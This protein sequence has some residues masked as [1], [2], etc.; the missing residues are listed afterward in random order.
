M[1]YSI[2]P[3]RPDSFTPSG[4]SL[5]SDQSK[6]EGLDFRYGAPERPDSFTPSGVSLK[7]DQSKREGLDFRYGA[8]ERPDSLTPS[9]VYLKSDQ[10]KRGF[11]FRDGAP[12]FHS[13]CCT[14]KWKHIL[15]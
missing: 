9:G 4:V 2:Q 10:S 13:R 14:V 7:S 11:D 6:R 1:V 15:Y 8:P 12:E 3:K 5:K